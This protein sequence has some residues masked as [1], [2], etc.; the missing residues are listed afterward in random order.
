MP[1]RRKRCTR[2]PADHGRETPSEQAWHGHSS[3]LTSCCSRVTLFQ[4]EGMA[5]Q[6]INYAIPKSSIA[7][8][9]RS[10]RFYPPGHTFTE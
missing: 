10:G 2:H 8:Q 1:A 7:G 5:R 4:P 9:L 3:Q 6:Q